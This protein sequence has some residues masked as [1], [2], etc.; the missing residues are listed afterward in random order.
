MNIQFFL[1]VRIKYIYRQFH[2]QN[3]YKFYK[4]LNKVNGTQNL[5]TKG[6]EILRDACHS[7]RIVWNYATAS[8]YLKNL[9]KRKRGNKFI[10]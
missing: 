8:P 4:D 3:E 2:K 1:N 7:K 6:L 9:K 5:S 10:I